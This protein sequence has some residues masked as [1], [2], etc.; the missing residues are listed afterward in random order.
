MAQTA[1]KPTTTPA[2]MPAVFGP[3]DFPFSAVG[4]G[5]VVVSPGAVTTTVFPTVT[6]DGA[7]FRVVLATGAAVV[8]GV[9]VCGVDDAALYALR[10]E[11]ELSSGAFDTTPPMPVNATDQALSPPPDRNG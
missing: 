11:L 5:A 1:A 7:D 9:A 10:V 2:A 8:C 6:T 4:A 3:L